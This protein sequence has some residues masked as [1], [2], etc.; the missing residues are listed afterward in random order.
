MT[1]HPG[2]LLDQLLRERF[3]DAREVRAEARRPVPD[4][5][6]IS[7]ARPF[8]KGGSG[9]TYLQLLLLKAKRNAA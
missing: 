2:S 8:A 9:L 1:E 5:D 4:S 7:P 3:P 6:Y